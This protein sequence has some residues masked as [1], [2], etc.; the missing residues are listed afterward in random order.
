MFARVREMFNKSRIMPKIIELV[1]E[2]V[3]AELEVTRD[4]ILSGSRKAE[5]VDARHMAVRLLY[6][7]NVY[8]SRIASALGLSRRSV[9]YAVTAFDSRMETNRALRGAYAKIAKKLGEI[10]EATGK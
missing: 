7:R 8:V 6:G 1:L 10:C 5:T 3:E 4:D 2:L 9:N